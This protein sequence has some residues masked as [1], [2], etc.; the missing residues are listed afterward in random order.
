MGS[1]D[2]AGTG[3]GSLGEQ[4]TAFSSSISSFKMD[5]EVFAS[6]VSP[7][8]FTLIIALYV[9]EIVIILTYFT[10]KLE[11]DNN[12]LAKLRIAR[13]LPVALT[14]FVVSIIVSNAV[15][16]GFT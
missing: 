5:P 7:A 16:G 8:Q 6:L 4:L 15:V 9:V 11:E 13:A 10:S 2:F 1:L 14:V 3:L 12:V